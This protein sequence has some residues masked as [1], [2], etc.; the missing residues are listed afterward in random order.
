MACNISN[1]LYRTFYNEIYGWQYCLA[2]TVFTSMMDEN[3]FL[4]NSAF[5][6]EQVGSDDW[7]ECAA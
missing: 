5:G 7:P 1:G 3:I 2:F 4:S 6:L